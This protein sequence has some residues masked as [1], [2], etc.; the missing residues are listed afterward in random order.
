[1]L[2]ST[3]HARASLWARPLEQA[4]LWAR[5]APDSAR[6]Q[7]YASQ[8]EIASHLDGAAIDRLR[9]AWRRHPDRLQLA[10]N[11][12]NA[13]C[14]RDGLTPADKDGIA[15][16]FAQTRDNGTM[17]PRWLEKAHDVAA[18]HGCAGLE[19]ADVDRWALAA[20]GNPRIHAIPG[21]RQDLLSLR[22]TVALSMGR[23][24]DALALFDRALLE[25]V[26]PDAAARQAATLGAAGQAP[27][28]LRHLDLYDRVRGQ[29]RPPGHGMALVHEWVLER[30]H[31]WDTEFA[32]L[33]QRLRDDIAQRAAAGG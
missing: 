6:A 4:R 10:L 9:D 14:E 17:V 3:L 16:S 11:F 29:A 22:G 12:A 33:R 25:D 20:F 30:Q 24:D 13:V 5:V 7:S 31:Y 8:M 27:L 1:V 2:A 19:L 28:G 23:P 21:R 18:T 26:R 32:A 15:E